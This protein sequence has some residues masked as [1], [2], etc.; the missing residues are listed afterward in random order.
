MQSLALVPVQHFVWEHPSFFIAFNSFRTSKHTAQPLHLWLRC[1]V[2]RTALFQLGEQNLL[3]PLQLG[4]RLLPELGVK[5]HR[6]QGRLLKGENHQVCLF[7]PCDGQLALD[8]AVVA[9]VLLQPIYW[10]LGTQTHYL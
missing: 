4:Q 10:S 5:G 7:H 8:L 2:R 6:H 1:R 9:V 3:E